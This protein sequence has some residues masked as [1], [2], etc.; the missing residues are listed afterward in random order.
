MSTHPSHGTK[1]LARKQRVAALMGNSGIECWKV[2]HRDSPN[3]AYQV[4][5]KQSVQAANELAEMLRELGQETSVMR[6]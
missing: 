5:I 2:L 3:E 6:L 1:P 4:E